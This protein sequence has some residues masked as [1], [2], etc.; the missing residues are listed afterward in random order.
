M[1]YITNRHDTDR[2]GLVLKTLAMEKLMA[3]QPELMQGCAIFAQPHEVARDISG[4]IIFWWLSA[5]RSFVLDQCQHDANLLENVRNDRSIQLLLT[6]DLLPMGCA[7]TR[8]DILQFTGL[9]E[10]LSEKLF[11]IFRDKICLLDAKRAFEPIGWIE[12]NEDQSSFTAYLWDDFMLP[13][14]EDAPEEIRS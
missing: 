7:T 6:A 10:A 3:R 12:Q 2:K 1:D 4:K 9:T 14:E 13:K 11:N 5:I 8:E